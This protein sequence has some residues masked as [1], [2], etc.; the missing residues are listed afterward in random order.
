M[1]RKLL[2]LGEPNPSSTESRV[3]IIEVVTTPLAFLV[4]GLLV[5]ES[6]LGGLALRFGLQPLLL[7]AIVGFPIGLIIV[8]VVLAKFWPEVLAGKRAW[9]T[10]YTNQFADDIYMALE[11]PLSNLPLEDQAEAWL[12]VADVITAERADPEYYAFCEAV[13]TRLIYKTKLKGRWQQQ[14]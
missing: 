6:L 5:I 13:A 3:R 2:M 8:V 7:N 1:A 9:R 4:L 10:E 12:T 11:G 14:R